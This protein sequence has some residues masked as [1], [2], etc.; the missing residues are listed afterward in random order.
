M[1]DDL[2]VSASIAEP[3]GP[4]LGRLLHPARYFRHPRDV[5]QADDIPIAEKRAIISSWASD[6]CAVESA[7]TLRLAPNSDC[8]IPYDDIIDALQ[9]LDGLTAETPRKRKS[10]TR[11]PRS[12]GR[13]QSGPIE[14]GSWG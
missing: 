12:G 11:R 14:A 9:E 1:S 6:A 10:H 5:L 2:T 3:F 4:E 8:A 7:P 13:S